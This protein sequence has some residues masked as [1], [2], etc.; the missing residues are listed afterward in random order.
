MRFKIILNDVRLKAFIEFYFIQLEK[1]DIFLT[2]ILENFDFIHKV[3]NNNTFLKILSSLQQLQGEL[4]T[5]LYGRFKTCH[6][7]E[8]QNYKYNSCWISFNLSD[9]PGT[10]TTEGIKSFFQKAISFNHKIIEF[11]DANKHDLEFLNSL[12][13]FNSDAIIIDHYFCVNFEKSYKPTLD[14]LKKTKFHNSIISVITNYKSYKNDLKKDQ[15]IEKAKKQCTMLGFFE[16]DIRGTPNH[17]RFLFL[18]PLLIKSGPG[19]DLGTNNK[20]GFIDFY[21]LYKAEFARMFFKTIK[22]NLRLIDSESS[23]LNES[24][25]NTLN[26]LNIIFS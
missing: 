14:F 11:E 9:Y 4:F 6:A 2:E 15:K 3:E 20:S 24:D 22:S 19:F 12:P 16:S 13:H 10:K 8:W 21:N 7:E 18:G 23:Y 26:K 5:R 17:D 1:E 25:K